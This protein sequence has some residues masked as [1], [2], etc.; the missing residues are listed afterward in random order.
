VRADFTNIFNR[1]EV[2]NP[3]S[4][5]AAATQT[6]SGAGQTTGGF[7]YINTTSVFA[8]PRQGTLVARFTF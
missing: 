6:L 1:A 8:Q 3:V 5:N 4:A 2:V 7:G